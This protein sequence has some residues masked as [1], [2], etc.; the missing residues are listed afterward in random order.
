MNKQDRAT[1]PHTSYSREVLG[2]AGW[3]GDY[4]CNSC[5]EI[6]TPDEVREIRE[7]DSQSDTG[8]GRER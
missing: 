2:M 1:C 6:L 4:V 7:R 8:K 5:G 3:S